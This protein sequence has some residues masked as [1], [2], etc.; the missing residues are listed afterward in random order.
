M[1]VGL[2]FGTTNTTAAI[3]EG[4]HIRLI[5]IDPTAP[6]PY[7][8]RSALFL[9]RDGTQLVGSAAIERYISSN[10]GR[11]IN[12]TKLVLGQIE[13]RFVGGT[14]DTPE[15]EAVIIQDRYAFV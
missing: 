13:K 3:V 15:D 14:E 12:Y 2:D 7:I 9:G 6:N 11:E 5:P 10:V 1:H 8:M 4:T